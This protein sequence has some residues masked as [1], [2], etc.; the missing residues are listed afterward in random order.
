MTSNTFS[1]HYSGKSGNEYFEYQNRFAR[2]SGIINARKFSSELNNPKIILDF[3]YGGGYM[4]SQLDA[5]LKYGLE[6]N[7]IAQKEAVRNGVTVFNDLTLIQNSSIDALVTN[8][9]LE[10]VFSPLGT[11]KEIYRV[12]GPNGRFICFLPLEDCRRQKNFVRLKSI[13]I[14]MARHHNNRKHTY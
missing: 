4:L 8:H 6:V 9:A 3:G 2:R 14:Y 10:H 7:E 13:I 1:G 12:L 11:L 5:D